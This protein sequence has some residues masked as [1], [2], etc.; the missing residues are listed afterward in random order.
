MIV[1]L[2]AA[3]PL[4]ASVSH[5]VNK[6]DVYWSHGLCSTQLIENAWRSFNPRCPHSNGGFCCMLYHSYG[7]PAILPSL[8]LPLLLIRLWLSL[9]ER[10]CI[11]IS[12]CCCHQL[13][14]CALLWNQRLPLNSWSWS[15]EIFAGAAAAAVTDVRVKLEG[16]FHR[17][18]RRLGF[19]S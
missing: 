12:Y 2:L 14:H 4:H 19:S 8:T 17:E 9:S 5:D 13:T 7:F 15:Q 1:Q 6:E 10:Q 18:T 11:N 16:D 3:E